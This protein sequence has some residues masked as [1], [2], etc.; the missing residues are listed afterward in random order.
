MGHPCRDR[1]ERLHARTRLDTAVFFT[2]RRKRACTTYTHRARVLCI[3]R[4]SSAPHAHRIIVRRTRTSARCRSMPATPERPHTPHSI[5][6]TTADVS[7]PRASSAR[8]HTPRFEAHG[9][10]HEHTLES[11]GILSAQAVGSSLHHSHTFLQ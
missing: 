1:C 3:L 6:C 8:E 11:I 5:A 10:A 7:I 2:T 9:W 4:Q